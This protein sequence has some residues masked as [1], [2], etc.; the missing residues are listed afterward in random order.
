[1]A[2]MNAYVEVYQLDE[3]Y[4]IINAGAL[5]SHH[6]DLSGCLFG[7]DNTAGFRPLFADR[8]MPED[9]SVNLGE[10]FGSI[11]EHTFGASW[12]TAEELAAIHWDE[13]A[14]RRDER[15][16][17]YRVSSAGEELVTKWLNKPGYED[18][19]AAL[20]SAEEVRR[21]DR[22]FRRPVIRRRDALVDTEF[23]TIMKL[24][25]VLTERYG[26]GASRLVVYFD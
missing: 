20:V 19:R 12:A 15:V 23:T 2:Q 10:R 18:I 4:E 16:H 11:Q 5:L 26:A 8:G 13:L 9:L 3:W 21:G 24:M 14:E 22:V 17:E 6:N 7:V 25:A 1:M